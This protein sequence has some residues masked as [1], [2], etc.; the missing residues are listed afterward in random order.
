MG[1]KVVEGASVLGIAV[2]FCVNVGPSEGEGL[3]R[4][5]VGVAL[6]V[7]VGSVPCTYVIVGRYANESDGL[8]VG[9]FEERS[10]SVL[11]AELRKGARRHNS[12]RSHILSSV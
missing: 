6:V 8:R 1:E 2:G 7:C 11:G 12:T 4:G 5:G 10:L 3:V 9:N